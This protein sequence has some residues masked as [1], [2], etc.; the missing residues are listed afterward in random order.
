MNLTITDIL[1]TEEITFLRNLAKEIKSQDNHGNRTPIY[2]EV[3]EPKMKYGV[4]LRDSDGE[5]FVFVFGEEKVE[6]FTIEEAK[7]HLITNYG[8][9]G[10]TDELK[11]IYEFNSLWKFCVKNSI[12]A[13]ITRYSKDVEYHGFFLTLQGYQKH[14]NLNGHNYHKKTGYYVS[15][16]FRNPELEKLI[17]IVM[18]FAPDDLKE[19]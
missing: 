13:Y 1:S 16:L 9:D 8:F 5:V 3:C 10:D 4:D 6:F 2:F 15:T 12:Y 18:K 17:E 19:N 11:E 14:M 7:A